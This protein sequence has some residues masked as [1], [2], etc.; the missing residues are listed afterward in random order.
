M[1][2][3]VIHNKIFGKVL[4]NR[5]QKTVSGYSTSVRI[6]LGRKVQGQDSH[7]VNKLYIKLCLRFLCGN[8]WLVY[9]ILTS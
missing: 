4:V 8:Y 3:S 7:L 2:V 9:L 6:S 5:A 1:S